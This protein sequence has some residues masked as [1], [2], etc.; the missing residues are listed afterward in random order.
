MRINLKGCMKMPLLKVSQNDI[1]RKGTN[2]NSYIPRKEITKE[3][4]VDGWNRCIDLEINKNRATTLEQLKGEELYKLLEDNKDLIRISRP[5]LENLINFMDEPGFIIILT[6]LNGY[7]IDTIGDNNWGKH[8]AFEDNYS[9]GTACDERSM[10]NTAIT[11]VLKENKGVQVLGDEHYSMNYEEFGCSSAPIRKDEK[12][13]GTLTI[14]GPKDNIHEH[15]LGMVLGMAKAIENQI[16][17]EAYNREL[18]LK[19]K[20]QAEIMEY[21]ND[22]FLTIDNKGIVTYMNNAGA[23]ILGID[24]KSSIGSDIRSLVD[25]EPVILDVIKTG[26][27]YC[28]KEFIMTNNITGMKYHF[29]KTAMAIR[30]DEGNIVGAIDNFRKITQVHKMVRKLVGNY[31]KFKFEDIIG[32]SLK[33]RECIRLAKVAANTTSRV[34]IYGESGTGKELLVQSIHNASSRKD[35]SLVSINCAAIPSGLIESELFGYES[36]A[37]TGALK[38]GQVGKFEL[39]N[40]GTLFLDEI[41]DMPLHMQCKLL[42]V[43][44]ENQIT[45]VGGKDVINVDVRI[46]SATNKDLL[47]EC[48]KGNFREDLYYRLNVFNIVSPPLRDRKEDIVELVDSFIENISSEAGNNVKGISREALEYL[49]EY[50]WPGNVRELENIIERAVNVCSGDILEIKDFPAN[51]INKENDNGI[52]YIKLDNKIDNECKI[53]TMESIEKEAI[54][55]TLHICE[56]NISRAASGLGISRNTL[57]NKIEKY[58]IG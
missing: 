31:G 30:D 50:D 40:G 47:S 51:L 17:I 24:L 23:D 34:L 38:D 3:Y 28:D 42:R 12:I 53:K 26:K 33:M 58:K 44:Q 48:K 27:G 9:I 52:T 14:R 16:V 43:L 11:T 7:V 41:G 46:I 32:S 45:R 6:D 49:I 22:G 35:G 36:G 1:R 10:G 4:I 39:A 56:G 21:I 5:F 13:I 29:I 54:E 18:Q 25:F 2:E 8:L 57:Y 55:K 19:T 20:Y 15:T 37:F